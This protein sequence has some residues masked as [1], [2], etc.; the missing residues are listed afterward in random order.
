MIV[1]RLDERLGSRACRLLE[2]Q[3]VDHT[4]QAKRCWGKDIISSTVTLRR[5]KDSDAR[6][7]VMHMSG[8]GVGVHLDLNL[9]ECFAIVDADE[10]ADHLG[11]HDD[12]PQV[13]P[14]WLRLLPCRRCLFLY[15]TATVQHVCLGR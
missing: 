7:H 13:C 8:E 9:V 6:P 4:P 10:G 1:V 14:H 3:G 12:V 15:P 11:Q 5:V 2:P